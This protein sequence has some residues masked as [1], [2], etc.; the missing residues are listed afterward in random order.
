MAKP[1][2]E[3][4]ELISQV[5]KHD[6]MIEVLRLRFIDRLTLE[7]VGERIGICGKN[8]VIISSLC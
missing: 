6:T 8:I 4:W 3:L 7:E 5:L 2:D 1:K